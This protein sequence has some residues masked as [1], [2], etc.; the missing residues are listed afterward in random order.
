MN[1]GLCAVEA[2]GG[3]GLQLFVDSNIEVDSALIRQLLNEVLTETVSLM[4]GQRDALDTGPGLEPPKPR[5][6]AAQEVEK[7]RTQ[8]DFF[9]L[10]LCSDLKLDPASVPGEI[11]SASPHTSTDP[12]TQSDPI[13]QRG[14]APGHTPSL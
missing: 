14:H 2:A 7:L 6:A 4:L 8:K 5:P 11:G 9:S 3:G 13:W 12:S 10:C 1:C